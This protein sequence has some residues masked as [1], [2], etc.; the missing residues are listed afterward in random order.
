MA[1]N[2]RIQFNNIVQNQMPA[3][4]RNEY[5][6]VSEFLKSYYQGQEYQGGPVDLIQNIDKYTK[7][8]KLSNLVD[9]VG[10]GSDIT[11]SEDTISVDMTSFPSGTEGFPDNWGLIKIDDE[12]ITYTN[13]TATSFTGCVRGFSGITT[14]RTE[15]KPDELTF[16][17]SNAASHTGYAYNSTG[18]LITTG[19]RIENLSSLFLNEFLLKT[20]HQLLPG[21]EDRKLSTDLDQELFIKQAK[22]FYLSKGTDRSFE[23]LFKALYDEDVKIVKPR[24][25][26]FTPSNAHYIV[27]NVL[28]VE[29][30]EGDPLNL[31]NQ[32]LFQ[33]K[34]NTQYEKAYAPISSIEKVT[35]GIGGTY[36]K[37]GLDAGYNR[38]VRVQGAVY[39]AFSVHAKTRN[40]GE[41]SSG[42]TFFNVDSTVG[43][44]TAGELSVTYNDYSA[45]IVSYTS[46]SLTQFFGCSNLTGIIPTASNI[47]I[48]T[49][50]FGASSVGV[51]TT[52]IKIRINNVLSDLSYPSDTYY[53]AKDDTVKIKTLGVSDK[54][55]KAKN[56]FYNI[57]P[58]YDVKSISQ[59]DVGEYE[60]TL[61]SEHCLRL[62]DSVTMISGDDGAKPLSTVVKIVS[63]TSFQI[64]G[65]GTLNLT[66]TYT[67][68]RNILQVESNTY[69]GAS[70]YATN[71]QNVYKKNGDLLVAS[72][73]L[74]S[75][76]GQPLEVS[77]Q[78][79]IFS[80]SFSGTEFKI[81]TTKDH[82]FYTGD[83][84]YYTPE[85]LLVAVVDPD[86]GITKYVEQTQEA[87]FDEGLYF[88]QRVNSTT[89]KLAKSRTNIYNSKFIEV[90]TTTTISN[91]KLEPYKFKGKTLQP[92]KILR[93]VSPPSKLG[94][95]TKTQPG[96]TGIL[97]NGGEI[98]NYKSDD[99][100]YY[101]KLDNIEVLGGGS[102]YDVI[103]PP[104]LHISDTTG[105]GA[106]GFPAISGSLSEIRLINP[107]YDYQGTPTVNVSGGNGSGAVASV[108][109]KQLVHKVDFSATQEVGNIGIGTTV[110]T[111]GFGTYHK[112][113]NGEQVSYL[114]YTQK[115]VSGLTTDA[116]Y[117]VSSI[118]AYTVKLH[119]KESDAISGI[120]TIT[121]LDYGI[122]KQSL[123]SYTPKSVIESIDVT[124]GGSGYQNKKR[125]TSPVGINTALNTI[126]IINHDYQSGEIVK[127]TNQG[128][129]IGGLTAN[130]EYY[131]TKINDNNFKLSSNKFNYDTKQY[132]DFATVGVGTHIFNYQDISVTLTGRIGIAS[133]GTETFEAEIQPVI[134][135]EITS[136]HLSENGVGYGSSD[137]ISFERPP[138][139]KLESGSQAQL[140]PIVAGGQIIRVDVLNSGKQY[141]APPNL[142]IAGSGRGAV[143]TATLTGGL[144]TNINVI[145]GGLGYLPN[146]TSVTVAYSGT[147]AELKANIQ[148]WRINLVEKYNS[149]FT[150]DDGFI[151]HRFNKDFGLQYSSLYAPRKLREATYLVDSAGTVLYGKPDLTRVNGKEVTVEDHSPIIGWAYDGHPIYGPYGYITKSGGVISQM[152]SGWKEDSVN[153]LNRPPI[154]ATADESGFPPGFFVEDYTYSEVTDETVLDENNGRF[155]VTPEYPK[156]TYAYFT[157]VDEG[158][159]ASSGVFNGYKEPKFPY[160][161]GDNYKSTP[162]NFNFLW[163]SN[164][165]DYELN[166]SGW[167]RNTQPYNLID[168]KLTYSYAYIPNK[169]DQTVDVKAVVPG[170]VEK[171]GIDT[172]GNNYRVGD[173]I[174]FDNTDTKGWDAAAKVSEVK[175]RP[176]TNI[177]VGSSILATQVRNGI[178]ENVE[179]YPS[180]TKGEYK[181]VTPQPHNLK[182]NNIVVISGLS[183]TSSEIGGDY[184]IGI[185]TATLVLAGVGTTSGAVNTSG[186]TGIVTYFS[187]NGNQEDIN[188]N[189]ILKIG[190]ERVKVLNT[191][192]ERGRIRVLRAVDGTTGSAHTASVTLYQDPRE[193]TVNAGFNTTYDIKLN[194]EIYFNPID[195]VATGVGIG[196]TI[197]FSN[198]G[199]GITNLFVP[200][201]S[202]YIKNHG[203]ET[204]DKLTYSPNVGT[205]LSV[206][207]NSSAAIK[208]LANQQTVYAAKI[209][210]DL[211]GIATVVVGLGTTSFVGIATTATNSGLLLFSG[212]GT[213]V[214]H[215]LRTNYEPITCEAQR[216]LVTVSTGST[217]GL[218]NSDKVDIDIAPSITTSHSVYYND[219][220]RRFALGALTI[221]SANVNI[222]NNTFQYNNHKLESGQKIIYVPDV[223]GDGPGGIADNGIYYVVKVDNNYISLSNTYYESTILKPVVIDITSAK[224]GKLYIVNPPLKVYKDSIVTFDVS[225]SSLAYTKQATSYSAFELAFYSDK[226]YTTRWDKSQSGTSFEVVR[227][228]KTGIDATATV[229][230]TANKNIPETLWYKLVPI[231]ESDIPTVKSEVIVD[232]EVTNSSQ[233]QTEESLYNGKKIITITGNSS[234][235]Y[236]LPVVPEESSYI[237]TSTALKGLDA[238]KYTTISTTAY[239]PITDFEIWTGGNNYYSIPGITTITTTYGTNAIVSASSTSI[240]DIR[241]TEI[242]DIGFNFPSD[243][244]LTPS[245][246]IPLKIKIGKLAT[247][248]S[249]GISSVGRGYSA[250]PKLLLFDGLTGELHE[251]VALKYTLGEKEVKILRN[252]TGLNDV[253]PVILPI[254]NTNGVGINTVGFNTVTKD[255][256]VTM[257]VGFST[258]NTFPF[259]VGDKVL[260]EGVSV[261][262]GSTGLGYNSDGY[263]YK[264]FTLNSVDANIGG[265]GTVGYSLATE[266]E[267]LS[268]IETPGQFSPVNSTAARIIAEKHFPVFD[269][270]LSTTE[271]FK[272]E[273]VTDGSSSG[274][275]ENWDTK[276]GILKVS[277]SEEFTAGNIIK[278]Q[279][280]KTQGVASTITSYDSRINMG[281]TSLVQKGWETDSGFLNDNIQRVQDSFYYQNL[282]YAIS[283]KVDI[284]TWD[285][286]VSTLNHTL[287]LKKFSDLQLVSTLNDQISV[288]PNGSESSMIIGVTTT[289]TDVVNDWVGYASLN[290]VYDFDLAKENSLLRDSGIVSNEIVFSSKTLTD[291]FESIGNRVLSVDDF[292]GDFNS[293]PRGTQYSTVRSFS[294]SEIRSKKVFTLIRDRRY[295]TQRQLMIVDLLHDNTFGYI[296][297]YGRVE[298]NYDQ[299]S[300]EFAIT[301]SQGE[302]RFYPT[303]YTVNDYDITCFSYNINDNLLG[304]G[305]TTVGPSIINSHST[306]VGSGTTTTIVSVDSAYSTLKVLVEVTA[307]STETESGEFSSTELNVVHNGSTVEILEYGSLNT[308]SINPYTGPG[309]GTYRGYIS[310]GEIKIDFYPNA[311]IGTTAIVNTIEVGLKNKLTT[312]GIGTYDMKHGRIE[313]RT[314]G[315]ASTATPTTNIVGQFETQYP[316]S[317]GYEAAYFIMQVADTAGSNVDMAELIVIDD[318]YVNLT[319]GQTSGGDT[320]DTEYGNVGTSGPAG[321]GGTFG[322]RL[323]ANGYGNNSTVYLE[324]TPPANVTTQVKTYMNAV[325]IQDDTRDTLSIVNGTIETDSSVYTGTHSDIRR[326]FQIYHENNPIFR[327]VITGNSSVDV[328]LTNNTILIPNHYFVT[329]EKLSYSYPGIG[330]TQAIGIA[331]TSFAGVGVTDFLPQTVYAVKQSED[332]I[333]L[334]SSAENALKAQPET[335]GFNT[336][337]VGASHAFC[338][339]NQNA[340]CVITLDNVM[341]SPVVSSAVTTTLAD[342]VYTTDDLIYFTGITSFYGGDLIQ[343]GSEILKIQGVGIGSTNAIRVER[344]WM[345][346]TLSGYATDTVV[347]KVVGN[348]NIVNNT[349]NFYTA[350]YG[351]VPESSPNN[352]PDDRDWVGIAT[353]SSVQ[354]RLFM[355]SG[356]QDTTSDTYAKNVIFDDISNQFNGVDSDFILKSEGSNVTGIVTENAIVLIND[357]FQY[358]GNLYNY[359]L[360]EGAGITTI[361]ITG[362]SVG[363][364]TAIDRETG[365][366][367]LPVGG[368]IVSVGSTYGNGYQPLVAAGGTAIVSAAGTIQSVSIGNTGSGYRKGIQPTVDVS[369]QQ[370]S[371]SGTNIV[372]VG[373]AAITDGHITGIAITNPHVFYKPRTVKNVGYSSVTGITTITTQTP[374]GLSLGEEVKLSGIALTC[375]YAPP[376]AISAVGYS[377]ATGIMTVTTVG[378]HSFSAGKDVIFTGL[379]MTCALDSGAATHYYPRGEDIAYDTSINLNAVGTDYSVSTATYNPTTGVMNLT[380]PGSSF[381]DGDKIMLD[382]YSVTFSCAKDNHQTLH[383]YP[384]PTDPSSGK[385]LT[386][387]NVS[388][389]SFDV[390]VLDTIPS[391]NTSA[392]TFSNSSTNGLVHQDGIITVNV[393]G[394]GPYDQSI[395]K[396]VTAAAG[397]VITG[398]NYNHHFVSATTGSVVS[399]GNYAHT[400]VSAETNSV[401]GSLTPTHATYNAV[402]GNMV[403][404]IP[405]HGLASGTVTIAKDALVFTCGMD[406]NTTNHAYPRSSDPIA[407]IST[408]IFDITADTFTVF[409]GISTLVTFTPTAADYT[410]STGIMTMTIGSHNFHAPSS[411]TVT[412]ATYDAAVGVLTCTVAG[413][414]FSV[415]EKVKFADNSLSFK[416]AMDGNTAVKTYPRSSDPYQGKWIPILESDTNTFSV[417]VG[418]SATVGHNISTASYNQTNGNLILTIGAHT[419]AVGERVK[420][421]NNSLTFK[422]SQDSYGSNHTYPRAGT[423]PIAGVGTYITATTATTITLAVGIGTTAAHQFVGASNTTALVSGG[424]YAHTFVSGTSGGLEK[425]GQGIKIVENGLTFRCA[426]DNY[427]SLHTYPRKTDPYHDASIAIAATSTNSITVQVG[428]TSIVNYNISTATYNASSGVMALTIG[429]HNLREGSSIKLATESLTFT[430]NKDSYA[431]QHKY[432]RKPDPT[433]GGTSVLS[434]G[435]GAASTNTFTV[436][437]GVSTVPTYYVSGGTV[438]QAIIAPRPNNNSASKVDIAEGGSTILG[439]LDDYNF[440]V[441]SG[442]STLYHLY[443]RGGK[444]NRKLDVLFE[445]P[446][447]YTNIP[448]DYS[449]TSPVGVGTAATINIEVGAGTSVINFSI[450]NS[451]RG[452]GVDE[453]LTVPLGGLTGI[454]TTGTGFAEFNLTI[455]DIDSDE[456]N[457]WS[458]GTLELLDDI[459]GLFD[460]ETVAFQTKK[461]DLA[462]T[463]RA[464]KG[465]NINVQDLLLIF[466]NDILQVPET[467]YTF[468]GGSL[469]TFTEA[470][471]KGDRCRIIFYKG[472]G[473]IDVTF[474]NIIE[475]IKTG[476]EVTIGYDPSLGQKSYLQEDARTISTVTSSDIAQT[477]PYFGPGNT[478]DETLV[479]PLNWCRQTEDK[480]INEEGIGKDR[481]LYEPVINPVAY[482]I[483][484]LGLTS[485]TIWLDGIQPFFNPYNEN[486]GNEVAFQKKIDI[487]PQEPKSPALATAVVSAAGTIS[488]LTITDGG[489]GYDFAPTVI[490]AEGAGIGSTATATVVP[491]ATGVVTTSSVSYGGTGYSVTSPPPVIIEAPAK[492]EETDSVSTF[493]GENGVIVGFATTSVGVVDKFLFDLHIPMDSWLRNGDVVGTA[494]T[495]SSLTTGD[496]FMVKNSN[497]GIGTTVITSRGIDNSVVA[498]GTAY[499]DNIYQVDTVSNVGIAQTLIGVAHAGTASTLCR[500]VFCRLTGISSETFSA[501]NITFDSTNYTFDNSG[502]STTGGGYP[503]TILRGP[504]FGDFSWGKIEVVSRSKSKAYNAYTHDGIGGIST[505]AIVQRFEPL[506]YKNYDGQII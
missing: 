311:G 425:A 225:D 221:P 285:D 351:N 22:D 255:V 232:T 456:F 286:V 504:F 231:F 321:I 251:E 78:A 408:S 270:K 227:T 162:H 175:G 409:V 206:R 469:I 144:I 125:T 122:G 461:D 81:T 153:K 186:T 75:Y 440:I 183:T 259:A 430:C 325:R 498:I 463:I 458:I 287:G 335:I 95:V 223:L 443:A 492:F 202:I 79:V 68:R 389:T 179:I 41:V 258:A 27:E 429:S 117:H 54:T 434:I 152:K 121:L 334:A 387:S 217:H 493:A 505:S 369:I 70:I 419:L 139:L 274:V 371:L 192:P 289:A 38:D 4:V 403:L 364:V 333:K 474:K 253:N 362:S 158:T 502:L 355:R 58:I 339:T 187:V 161:I 288:E 360:T 485:T 423:D 441:N 219:F 91:N 491:N 18:K 40:I 284:D 486:L 213:G 354:G 281:P 109:M 310:G 341:Q 45:G 96:F 73:S 151:P 400:F 47:G 442:I 26:L 163:D 257:A 14:Y 378:V 182:K 290:C 241:R 245:S 313:S 72:P 112:F 393:G 147:G 405:S 391:S 1:D 66:D 318:Y 438:Q 35:P 295:Y 199:T 17:T 43:F 336:V 113:R 173:A 275:V 465:S 86:T 263:N 165:D 92:Q 323:D 291:Y 127:Y 33:N 31:E 77:T 196:T 407:G 426:M 298:T 452:Y 214:Y 134:R 431:T 475:T 142:T 218:Q 114:T 156:G 220:N 201:A 266:F 376:I 444:V 299:G 119:P 51:G 150:S 473:G 247:L 306:E 479:R 411:H 366:S 133:V 280:S 3:Y 278:G 261:G 484:P 110:S 345:G 301:G 379:G 395:H 170:V 342:S 178:T 451:G 482:M 82:G 428:V 103:N 384:R 235:T 348:Y 102:N 248:G 467:G 210:D 468:T 370:E 297:Q 412:G 320:Y 464:G 203:L 260:I 276:I 402:T 106:T 42:S 279:S 9:H 390:T 16:N 459:S 239:G 445:D 120:N 98:A 100:I 349:L 304:V 496:Y 194:K 489:E 97:V 13:K 340:K 157:T 435:A 180:D 476:D 501:T 189:D 238:L 448:V 83:A 171:I 148:T 309:F 36:Y 329:G 404:T 195:S 315:I 154:A 488:G 55:Y 249:I 136:V 487:I 69:P 23:I 101:G 338:A 256:T 198:P 396:F 361:S 450:V 6:L 483:R 59:K 282:S 138:A 302:L 347:T 104:V 230:L 237:A 330:A 490:V 116:L 296:S 10:L 432:P 243:T 436:N 76:S 197:T 61:T 324:Y 252:S 11:F 394:A 312:S 89:V 397:A 65:Q 319:T 64:R 145:E 215:S 457:G 454:P 62:G 129:I 314:V 386:I 346:T 85:K 495:L 357:V 34:Y 294:L 477:L 19:S 480:I 30:L 15:T 167:Y 398:G 350:P 352:Q 209:N 417:N 500:R 108:R 455:D 140:K 80:G 190:T 159:A 439:V 264:R 44:P 60:V 37:I 308:K 303:K 437:I 307:D 20:K 126:Q 32:T 433:Y 453:V 406:Q 240:G 356:V 200:T 415:G 410:P 317:E 25:F 506:K 21:L 374:H 271:F 447:S 242:N 49:Y 211:V 392:H 327:R 71:V 331:S 427:E 233:I 5:P 164:Q 174:V 267:N 414:N 234:F 8:N 169:L 446:A 205:G 365:I 216:N 424:D 141:N 28:V 471:K 172:G 353:G 305:Q 385:W 269:V 204:G 146:D 53:Y 388:G 326:S 359:N 188:P 135:G 208:Q 155:C 67:V 420:I 481:E 181:V 185:T 422:C 56:W 137:V 344:P 377:T 497:I 265:I 7:I 322:T 48:N 470:P 46:K 226:D 283:S 268:A 273:T 399:G 300:F 90:A 84:V 149:Q 382:D 228:G 250:A 418:T 130:S 24:D 93:Q 462:V 168:N 368:V 177:S 254:E 332:K 74:P 503:G 460:G 29:A 293:N 343:I 244:T 12:I 123:K 224:D 87:L 143:L 372:A 421:Q 57:A 383:A 88:V 277:T 328:D 499:F 105:V 494:I 358:P 107:G 449:S 381:S 115:G 229:K 363:L 337:G 262:V 52:V 222:T 292:S 131:L 124:D 191:E 111:I 413:S 132:I 160:L 246:Q 373:T 478:E 472:T 401:N 63:D 166:D 380:V 128:T 316:T 94:T 207:D 184:S 367:S 50:A 375:S 466:I 416:C 193:F 212:I 39:G 236:T 2:T 176:I 99:V 272:G 118:D